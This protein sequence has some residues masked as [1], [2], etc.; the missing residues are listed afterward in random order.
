MSKHKNKDKK[1]KQKIRIYFKDGKSNIIPQKF[2]DDY[3]VNYGLFVVK[4]NEQWIAFYSLDMIA[5]AVIW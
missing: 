4:K 2:W 5:C 1:K 3:E